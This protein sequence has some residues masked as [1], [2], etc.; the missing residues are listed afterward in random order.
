MLTKSLAL[1]LLLLLHIMV[2]AC[3]L[4]QEVSRG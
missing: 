4:E 2:A 3:A 1:L